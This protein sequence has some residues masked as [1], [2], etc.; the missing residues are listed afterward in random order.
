M[1][2][3]VSYLSMKDELSLAGRKSEG[4]RGVLR[5]GELHVRRTRNDVMSAVG[6]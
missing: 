3:G 6:E 5:C 4:L 1:S 2:K